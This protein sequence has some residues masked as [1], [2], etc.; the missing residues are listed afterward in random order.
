MNSTF[1]RLG[2]VLSQSIDVCVYSLK[3]EELAV[4]YIQLFSK[5]LLRRMNLGE[6]ASATEHVYIIYCYYEVEFPS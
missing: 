5:I 1:Q 4:I 3:Y 6:T 2:D